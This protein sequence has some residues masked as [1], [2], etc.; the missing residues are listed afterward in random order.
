MDN[1]NKD[2][3]D[4]LF[5]PFELDEKPPEGAPEPAAETPAPLVDDAP[6]VACPSCGTANPAHNRHCESCGARI[7]QGPLP[8]AP[9]VRR[10]A[11]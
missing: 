5:E 7:A 2:G 4:D 10:F 8:V 3:F 6:M 9:N 1:D 11:P